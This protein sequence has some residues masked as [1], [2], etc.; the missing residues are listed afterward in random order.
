MALRN[1][2][3]HY[4]AVLQAMCIALYCIAHQE[5]DIVRL[6]RLATV[7]NTLCEEIAVRD[8]LQS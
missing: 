1:S 3:D 2:D 6:A 5:I 7:Y 8:D 4:R